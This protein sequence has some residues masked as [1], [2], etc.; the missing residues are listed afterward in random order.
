MRLFYG[1]RVLAMKPDSKPKFHLYCTVIIARNSQ[2]LHSVR[3]LFQISSATNIVNADSTSNSVQ[4]STRKKWK[5]RN[6][7]VAP[8]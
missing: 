3:I 4:V 8:R 7:P 1:S 5:F 2:M 6:R